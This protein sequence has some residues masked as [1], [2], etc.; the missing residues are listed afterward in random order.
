MLLHCNLCVNELRDEAS[1]KT[2]VLWLRMINGIEYLVCKFH[3]RDYYDRPS[4][5]GRVV[6]S[7]QAS[8]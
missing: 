8:V 2:D 4:K 5:A 7:V 6:P 3:R 1:K